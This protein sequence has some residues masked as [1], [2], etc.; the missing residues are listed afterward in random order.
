VLVVAAS[1]PVMNCGGF[2]EAQHE[3]LMPMTR[4]PIEYALHE[5]SQGK[6][7]VVILPITV[8]NGAFIPI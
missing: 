2:L 5:G 3:P 6:I 8:R 7:E 4:T 1:T